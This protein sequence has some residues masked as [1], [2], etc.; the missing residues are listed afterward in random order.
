[1]DAPDLAPRFLTARR[2]S[3]AFTLSFVFQAVVALALFLVLLASTIALNQLVDGCE[4]AFHPP[5]YLMLGM[6]ALEVAVYFIGL[7]LALAMMVSDA[8]DFWRTIWR[9]GPA[10]PGPVGR[11]LPSDD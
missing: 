9:L 7:V 10:S 3:L 1:M 11:I 8:I 6:R 2:T 5:F 4:H